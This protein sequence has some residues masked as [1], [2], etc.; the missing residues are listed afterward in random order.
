MSARYGLFGDPVAHSRSPKIYAAFGL[1]YELV[2]V[3][4][5]GFA[6][7]VSVFATS[8][9]AGANC[10]LPHKAA[11]LALANAASARA[12]RAGVANLLRF[13]G[14]GAVFADN[15]DGAGLV[16]DLTRNLG[17][18][19]AGQ[20]IL[21]VGTGGAASGIIG[22]LLDA[23][24]T[25]LVLCGRSLNKAQ[26]LAARF[27]DS[28]RIEASTIANPG[29][30]FDLVINATSASLSG[31]VPDVPADAVA[32]AVVYDLC[33]DDRKETAF[34]RWAHASGAG[35]AVDG[36]GMLVEQAAESCFVWTG[37]RPETVALLRDRSSRVHSQP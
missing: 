29:G 24:P 7:A 19:L 27:S 1:D 8:G 11:A 37:K 34:T 12:R 36:W 17:L 9:G 31:E 20:R 10:T 25:E 18:E 33:Y 35:A 2:Q 30:R 23:N 28:G 16:T 13:D 22:P 21:I 14:D 6:E 26:A 5:A 32:G 4:A 15:T 3:N